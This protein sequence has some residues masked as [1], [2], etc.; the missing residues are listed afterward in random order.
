MGPDTCKMLF[1]LFPSQKGS[2]YS[3]GNEVQLYFND[4]AM[5]MTTVYGRDWLHPSSTRGSGLAGSCPAH[6]KWGA[7]IPPACNEQ[8]TCVAAICVSC[9]PVPAAWR[10]GGA[11]HSPLTFVG[12]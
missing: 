11:K 7:S 4:L 8:S 5:L 2:A 1:S 6:V 12:P 9:A 3:D 10:I